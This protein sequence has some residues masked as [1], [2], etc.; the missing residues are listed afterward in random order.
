MSK[1][2]VRC[3]YLYHKLVYKLVHK[4]YVSDPMYSQN[5]KRIVTLHTGHSRK[6]MEL[7]ENQKSIV[8]GNISDFILV[9]SLRLKL[10]ALAWLICEPH[11]ISKALLTIWTCLYAPT[12]KIFYMF[13]QTDALFGCNAQSICAFLT[14]Y[15]ITFTEIVS[16]SFITGTT[17]L[18]TTQ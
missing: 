6:L 2:L 9:V 14:T 15:W 8:I 12:A 11:S 7:N 17:N 16:I 1:H 18:H 5:Y 13:W 3:S 10:R 4:I